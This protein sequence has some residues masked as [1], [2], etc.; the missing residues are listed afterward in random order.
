MSEQIIYQQIIDINKQINKNQ[1]QIIHNQQQIITM[2]NQ[3]KSNEKM[4]N[5]TSYNSGSNNNRPSQG[6]IC[7]RR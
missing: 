7:C 1:Q 5:I 6:W 4:I 2:I 3:H